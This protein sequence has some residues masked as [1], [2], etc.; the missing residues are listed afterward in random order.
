MHTTGG[1]S[2]KLSDLGQRR[3]TIYKLSPTFSM[4]LRWLSGHPTVSHGL[5]TNR[6]EVTM[7]A[8]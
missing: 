7:T 5:L 8:H 3:Q 6:D 2:A 1:S 4:P